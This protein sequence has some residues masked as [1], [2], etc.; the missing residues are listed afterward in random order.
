MATD[1]VRQAREFGNLTTLWNERALTVEDVEGY[2]R[3]EATR[4]KLTEEE[5]KHITDCCWGIYRYCTK[6][7]P[8]GH[9]LTNM[10][11]NDFVDTVGSADKTNVKN[12]DVYVKFLYNVAP[13]NALREARKKLSGE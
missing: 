10:L 4:R 3:R 12:L 13:A 5:V 6:G 11:R 1:I 2:I 9:F 7:I 8:P